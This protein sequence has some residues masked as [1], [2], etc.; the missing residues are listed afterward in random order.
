MNYLGSKTRLIE[1]LI[2]RAVDD[3]GLTSGK[4]LDAFAGTHAVGIAMQSRGWSV[5]ANDI[6]SYS[7]HIGRAKL[8]TTPLEFK[9]LGGSIF[10]K[11]TP[12]ADRLALVVYRLNFMEYPKHNDWFWNNYCENGSAGRL[13]FSARNGAVI[14]TARN[15][16]DSWDLTSLE[17]SVLIAAVIE[18]ADKIANVATVYYSYLK[19]LKPSAKRDILIAPIDLAKGLE[20]HVSSLDVID[21]V[22]S[23]KGA[24]VLYLDPPYN[25]RQYAGYY[26]MLETIALWDNPTIAGVGGVR[27][28]S[29]KK[30]DWCNREGAIRALRHTWSATDAKVIMLSYSSDGLMTDD[31]IMDILTQ[32]GTVTR[33]DQPYRRLKTKE[34]DQD[35]DVYEY[36]YIC[37]RS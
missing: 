16:I 29:D 24:D 22:G 30:S 35:R 31:D 10:D 34:S 13:Y 20:A 8:N 25:A 7:Y 18:G 23:V 19:K 14:Q 12:I 2:Q 1:P 33:L 11:D 6:Q 5:Y 27:P 21:F 17:R 3:L 9:S 32:C 28:W 36:L 15:L 37:N 4:F 26:H